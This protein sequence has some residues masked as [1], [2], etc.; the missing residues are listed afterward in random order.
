MKKNYFLVLLFSFLVMGTN[1]QFVDY[2][3]YESGDQIGNWWGCAPPPSP[4]CLGINTDQSHSGTRSGSIPS[5]GTTDVILDLG[6]KIF[7]TWQL[8]FWMYIPSNRVGYFNLQGQVP[9][10]AGEWIVGNFFFNQDNVNP[11]V[12]LIDDTATGEVN[13]NFPHDEW[14]HLG[15]QFDISAGIGASTW[16]F[17]VD[18]TEVIPAGTPFRNSAGTY[19]TSLG[20]VEFFSISTDNLYY[21]DDFCYSQEP[22][23][24]CSLGVEEMDD[25]GFKI[26]PNP[27]IDKLYIDSQGLSLDTF[28]IYTLQGQVVHEATHANEIDVSKLPTGMYF[29]Q[30]T[31]QGQ[32][33]TKKFIKE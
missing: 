18:F 27:V 9:I 33:I 3:E 14:F 2:M 22:M 31:S 8:Q 15:M 10:G 1:A 28:T 16:E 21:L 25:T 7:G 4:F 23:P 24:I 26:Y 13:F 30:I 17:S 5:D 12:G 19:P 6:N 11:G 20:G 29:I 32:S